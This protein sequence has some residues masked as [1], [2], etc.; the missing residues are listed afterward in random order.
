MDWISWSIEAIGAVIFVIWLIVPIREFGEIY[1]R[2]KNSSGGG[3]K[4]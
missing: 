3:E 1:R 2:I 4:K